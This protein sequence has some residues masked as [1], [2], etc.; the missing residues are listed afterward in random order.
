MLLRVQENYILPCSPHE[1]SEK[2]KTRKRAVLCHFQ[3]R[4]CDKTFS[5]LLSMIF[6]F[7]FLFHFHKSTSS[8][9]EA[10]SISMHTLWKKVFFS[11]NLIYESC[12][13]QN[14]P[15]EKSLLFTVLCNIDILINFD[16]KVS[17]IKINKGD[18]V[19]MS[20]EFNIVNGKHLRVLT[21][22]FF[23]NVE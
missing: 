22:S 2:N 19:F 12:W 11:N 18:E 14:A 4:H 8:S 1:A 17:A 23:Q 9:K 15:A 16:K 3:C 13:N 6:L 20:I 7:S 5:F 21:L 10:C